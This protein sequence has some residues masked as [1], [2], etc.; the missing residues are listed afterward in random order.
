MYGL[1]QINRLNDLARVNKKF[2]INGN[3]YK[4]VCNFITDVIHC[5]K[6]NGKAVFDT[7]L[8]EY[9]NFE[10][11]LEAFVAYKVSPVSLGGA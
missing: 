7:T 6:R 8:D 1:R 5:E 3:K 2:T 4:V 11:N 9:T 10:G